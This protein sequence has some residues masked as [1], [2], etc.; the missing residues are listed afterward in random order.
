VRLFALRGEDPPDEK[1]VVVRAG[2]NSL[3]PDVLTRTG[4]RSHKTFGFYG[5]SVWLAVDESV[6]DL[7]TRLDEI[8]RYGQIRTSSVGQIRECGFALLATGERPHFDIVLPDLTE[9]TLL[10]L[11]SLFEA[12]Q[13]NP[14]RA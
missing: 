9:R 8:R 10:R 13:A 12:P 2:V 11:E 7:C 4:Q 1:V 14:A 6:L 5:V 3:S